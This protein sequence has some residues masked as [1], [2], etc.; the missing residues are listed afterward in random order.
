MKKI[1]IYFSASGVTAKRARELASVTGSDIQAIV[2]AQ[3][4]SSAD[5][6]W[7]DHK[8]RSYQENLDDAVRP[9]L[10][11]G[12]VDFAGYDRIYLGFPIWWGIAPKVINTFIES[13]DLRNKE[14][15]IFATSGGSGLQPSVRALKKQY[16]GLDIKAGKLLNSSVKGD[17]I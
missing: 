13:I 9:A 3:R 8:S 7:T 1:V 6:D 2:P 11:Q 5:L 16:P 10:K 14:I 17:I 4:Y 12:T 15:V